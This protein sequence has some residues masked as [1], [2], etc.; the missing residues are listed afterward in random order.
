MRLL[1]TLLLG[2]APLFAA[3]DRQSEEAPQ[4]AISAPGTSGAGSESYA[5]SETMGRLSVE[6]RGSAAPDLTFSNAEGQSVSLSDFQGQPL[7]VNLWATWCAPCIREMPTL[8]A[9]A[10]RHQGRL[11]VLTVSQDFQGADVVRPF[12]AEN[13]FDNLEPWLD[14]Q[15]TMMLALATDTLPVTVLY[16]A[17]G[18]E[19]FRIYGGMDWSGERAQTLIAG[20]LGD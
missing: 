7:L 3:C 17:D 15:N 20:A 6:Y 14:S 13:E 10:D 9:L 11:K 19:L 12:F 4:E 2:C 8:D 16:D 18:A 5:G 1:I